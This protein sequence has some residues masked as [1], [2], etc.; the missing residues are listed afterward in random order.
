M[1]NPVNKGNAT[2]FHRLKRALNHGLYNLRKAQA[3]T[4]TSAIYVTYYLLTDGNIVTHRE[5]RQLNSPHYLVAGSRA[6]CEG[7]LARITA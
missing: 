2:R 3:K 4:V 1:A 6:G 7:H 5:W